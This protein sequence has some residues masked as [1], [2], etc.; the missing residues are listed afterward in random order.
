MSC[1]FPT[2]AALMTLTSVSA[3]A[4]DIKGKTSRLP[5]NDCIEIGGMVVTDAGP[6][7]GATEF[8]C[9]E[10]LS[11]VLE[12]ETGRKGN[13]AVWTVID[14]ITVSK[15]SPR[16]EFLESA[17]CS[18]SQFPNDFVF[19]LGEMVELP[20]RSYRSENVVAAWRFDIQSE[21][22]AAIPVEGML[23]ELDPGD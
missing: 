5:T 21:K 10:K 2:L 7:Y 1:Y 3:Q 15:P 8:K 17:F 13:S 22:M 23:C 12:R 19:A 9:G 14:R 18:S 20:D 11:L 4:G 16:H 6:T